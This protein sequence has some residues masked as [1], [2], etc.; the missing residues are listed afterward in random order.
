MTQTAQRPQNQMRT[1]QPAA[2]PESPP[3]TEESLFQKLLQQKHTYTPFGESEEMT[4]TPWHVQQFLAV[5]TKQGHLPTV[6]DCVKFCIMCRQR[7][8]NP[9]AGDC[10]MIGYDTEDGPKFS[11]V[12]A[13]QALLSRAELNAAFDGMES[14][15][16]VQ[17]AEVLDG[18]KATQVIEERQ[19][20]LTLTGETLLGGWSR[21]YRKDRKITFYQRLKL[22]TY[23]KGNKQWRKDGAGMICK[24]AEAGALRQAFPSVIG[25]LYLRDEIEA[26]ATPSAPKPAN[27][28]GDVNLDVLTGHAPIITPAPAVGEANGTAPVHDGTAGEDHPDDVS[29][30]EQ[31]TGEAE[32]S[33]LPSE[34]DLLGWL[35]DVDTAQT[36]GALDKLANDPGLNALSP[37]V[38][39]KILRSI[40]ERRSQLKAKNGGGKQPALPGAQQ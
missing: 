39:D 32:S 12:T 21:V 19:G 37:N 2:K 29:Q 5:P 24:C 6:Q 38:R 20:D 9:W 13:I 35:H 8:L 28:E 16:V 1:S 10:Y 27:T 36:N 14:G 3:D 23:D 17:R 31:A 18:G 33:Q 4:L 25:G 7:Q 22:G 15:V 40:G 11:V 26:F 34:E 30:E